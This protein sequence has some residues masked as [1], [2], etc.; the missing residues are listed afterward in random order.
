M[1]REGT[2]G[3]ATFLAIAA[4]LGVSLQSGPKQAE[5]GKTDRNVEAKRSK[6]SVKN[7]NAHN[8]RTGCAGLQGKI[9][10]FLAI[11][12][13]PPP[14]EC[15]EP[16]DAHL[17]K[18][19][20]GLS[21]KT[22]GLKFV[23]ALMPDPIHTHSSAMFD[24]FAAA[25]QEGAQDEKYD[26]DSSWLP[27]DD[28]ESSHML[29]ADEEIVNREKQFEESQPGIILFRRTLLCSDEV[30]QEGGCKKELPGSY[31]R[32]LIVFVVGEEATRG[33]HKEQFQNALEWI[34]WLQSK[35]DT[36]VK[37]LAILGPT[38]SGSFPS[39]AQ[40]LID[41]RTAKHLDLGQPSDGQRLAIY[42][43]SAS[44]LHAAQ[45]FQNAFDGHVVFH[46]FVQ[47]DEEILGRFCKYIMTEQPGFDPGRVAIIS[48]DETAYGGAV[49]APE[50]DETRKGDEI[51]KTAKDIC[52][53]KALNLYYPRDISAL[54]GAYQTKSLFAVGTST[55]P[56]DTQSRNLPTDLADPTGNVH[57]SIRGYGG[58][59]TPLSQEAFLME[60]VAALRELHARYVVLRSSN[61]LDQLFLANFLR[62]SYPDGRIV[63]LGSDLMFIRERGSTGLS[64][65]MTLSTYPLFPL[66]RDWTEH[67][68]LPAADRTFSSD[69]T[70]GTYVAF[71][72]LLN[73]VSLNGGMSDPHRCHVLEGPNNNTIFV[74]S[75]YCF[76]DP[77]IPDYSPPLLDA[78]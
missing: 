51:D 25:I 60:I 12:D 69:T 70:E 33:I 22:S 9:E 4:V 29:L 40:M 64:G 53:E 52:R 42:S 50:D 59:Q 30:K 46:S 49:R 8:E 36:R 48:E 24:Q 47:S 6:A 44:S 72:L 34:A 27:W 67:Q 78:S 62:R 68:S 56:S 61:T 45:R 65:A 15:L 35:N 19:P 31:N 39:V 18:P 32:G 66:E 11:E 7:H 58:N 71:R 55:L 37:S 20:E 75:I 23:I 57:D 1:K 76:E 73:D 2:I 17:D 3:A 28:A 26:F 13:L 38:F 74:P 77:P 21:D 63:I 43:G 54:R 10:D 41:P 14:E 5:S 16:D